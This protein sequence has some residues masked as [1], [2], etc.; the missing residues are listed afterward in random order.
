[1]IDLAAEQITL[2]KEFLAAHVPGS[3]VIAF[4]SRV[5]GGAKPYSDLDLVIRGQEALH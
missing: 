5:S 4:G 1:M 2:V 3:E